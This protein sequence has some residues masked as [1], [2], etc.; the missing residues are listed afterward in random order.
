ML[1]DWTPD[2][3]ENLDR[4]SAKLAQ[5]LANPDKTNKAWQTKLRLTLQALSMY[6]D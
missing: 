3:W 6:L 4:L 2:H 5:L 1:T